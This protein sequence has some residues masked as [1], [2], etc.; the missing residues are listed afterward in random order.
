M[1]FEKTFPCDGIPF[2]ATN[3]AE[4]WLE[5]R[6]YSVG[7]MCVGSPRGILKGDFLISKWRGLSSKQ[8]LELDGMLH[9][10]R[11]GQATIRLHSN[12]E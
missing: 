4:A 7:S 2:T 1:S 11:T 12:P 9:C 3:A 8:I 5:D 6:G 10:G